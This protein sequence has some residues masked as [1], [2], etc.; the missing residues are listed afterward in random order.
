MGDLWY[1]MVNIE[2]HLGSTYNHK[3]TNLWEHL[4]SFLLS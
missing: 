3:D 2:C 4:Q 1:V